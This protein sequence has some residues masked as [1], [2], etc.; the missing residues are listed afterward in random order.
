[1]KKFEELLKN[2]K[3]EWKKIGDII[4]KFSEKQ[5]NKV[6]L[7]LVYTVS[8]EYGLI[9]SKEY[10]K[11]KERR[12]DYTVYSEDLSNYNIIKKKYVCI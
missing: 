10:W 6:N 7:K 9:S 12:E 5:R 4:T 11:N 2:E 8:K 3:V 1:M